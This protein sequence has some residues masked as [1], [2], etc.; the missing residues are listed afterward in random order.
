MSY[1]LKTNVISRYIIGCCDFIHTSHKNNNREFSV[2]LR[3]LLD[4]LCTSDLVGPPGRP[5]CTGRVRIDIT[6]SLLI[7]TSISSSYASSSASIL[8]QIKFT[9]SGARYRLLNP[10]LAQ[11]KCFHITLNHTLTGNPEEY[12][13]VPARQSI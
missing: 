2:K 7:S 11:G 13:L 4:P 8:T 10:C 6:E 9:A 1:T 12:N 5:D 3:P